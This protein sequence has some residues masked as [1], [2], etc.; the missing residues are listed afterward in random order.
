VKFGTGEEKKSGNGKQCVYGSQT[1]NV[2]T[3]ELGQA[4]WSQAQA[5]AKS[6]VAGKLPPGVHVTL[7]TKDIASV[8]DRASTV[9]GSATI[10]G[11]AVGF[12][13]IYALKGATFFAFQDLTVG[14]GPPS[15]AK[16]TSQ[17][18][19]TAGRVS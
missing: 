1:R 5:Q 9:Y 6:L 19:T 15:V 10:G 17:A 2:F 13:G 7:D 8:G 12:S 11:E 4:E 3:V 16:M 14:Q 18:K